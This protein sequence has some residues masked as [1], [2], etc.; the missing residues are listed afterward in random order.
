MNYATHKIQTNP[1]FFWTAE[2]T[3]PIVVHQGGTSSGKTYSILQYLIYE[4]CSNPNL[5][6]T[7]VG[8]DIPNLK[9]G[10]Y[11]DVQKIVYEDPYFSMAIVSHN[12]S[13][14]VM[15]FKSG[16]KI[17]FNSYSDGIDARSGK[18]THSFFNEANGISYEIFEQVSLRTSDKVIIDFN[19]SSAFWAHDKLYG[20]DDVDWF[21]STFN[22]NLYLQSSIRD[23]ILSYEPTTEN[24][25]RGTANQFRWQ[26][27]GLGE[28][29]RLEGLVFP[30]FEVVNEWPKDYK[31]VS[32]GMDFGFTNDPTAL[33]EIRYA[34]GSLYWKQH[35]YRKALTN[36]AIARII[37]DLGIKEEIVADSAEPK[38]I[39]EIKREGVWIVPAVKGKDS[40][41]Y[42][43]QML[44]DY[45]IKIHAQSKDLIE[46]FSS[47]TWAKDRSGESTNKLID[48]NNH[49]IDA[50]RY[51]V[52]RRL[53]KRKLEFEL[54]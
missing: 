19:P 5:I 8:Q 21:V 18:R 7:V 38:S 29:G 47:Y 2:S 37:N 14:R 42:G 4:A 40:I 16:S 13:E 17:E 46:E 10:A 3:K 44:M 48:K 23:K 12:K 41:N 6:I 50:G 39:A 35:I 33:V 52:M 11:R 31:W 51:A 20:R 34:H 53:G 43:I 26:V 1:I 45:P 27:Y 36:Q 9:A 28:V 24:I 49:A 22:D 54:V 25:K 32:Y 30:T 15:E